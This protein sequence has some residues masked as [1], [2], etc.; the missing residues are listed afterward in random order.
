[1][2]GIVFTAFM[3]GSLL[4]SWQHRGPWSTQRPDRFISNL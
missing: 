3:Y 4:C 1:M 2:D